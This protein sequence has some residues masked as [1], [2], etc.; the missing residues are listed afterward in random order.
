M[1]SCGKM[2]AGKAFRPVYVL[3]DKYIFPHFRKL[4]FPTRNEDAVV[5][6]VRR[7]LP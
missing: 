7:E 4:S 3:S 6:A 2:S 5:G 1:P